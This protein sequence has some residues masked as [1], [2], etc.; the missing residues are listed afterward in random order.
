MYGC[1]SHKEIVRRKWNS[2]V[3]QVPPKYTYNF[4]EMYTRETG[5]RYDSRQVVTKVLSA[6]RYL[7]FVLEK[8][9][10]R[11]M[12]NLKLTAVGVFA[13]NS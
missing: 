1:K 12:C 2:C 8:K 5:S 11:N 10:T 9:I 3:G 7:L 13:S 4:L 6:P